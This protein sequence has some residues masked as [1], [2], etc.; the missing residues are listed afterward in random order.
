MAKEYLWNIQGLF[1]R[2][3]PY[4]GCF[5]STPKVNLAPF[6]PYLGCFLSTPK[7]NLALFHPYPG[8][9]LSIPKVNL[10]PFHPYSGRF[11]STINVNLACFHTYSGYSVWTSIIFC[12]FYS[13]FSLVVICLAHNLRSE[14]LIERWWSMADYESWSCVG[15]TSWSSI[16]FSRSER[17]I[18]R[19]WWMSDY[20]KLIMCEWH[21]IEQHPIL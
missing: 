8:C 2:F 3:H 15:G 18:E 11:P 12:P 10:A 1:S 13:D 19:W 7:V 21:L 5:L 16:L 14:R 9:F 4:P 20:E 6:H 17:L